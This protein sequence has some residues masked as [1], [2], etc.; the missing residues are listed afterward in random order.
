MND[1]PASLTPRRAKRSVLLCGLLLLLGI[2]VYGVIAYFIE[3]DIGKPIQTSFTP[4]QVHTTVLVVA[5]LALCF[6]WGVRCVM[7]WLAR[8]Y[9]TPEEYPMAIGRAV[10]LGMLIAEVPV[11]LGLVAYLITTNVKV[12]ALVCAIVT[13]GVLSHLIGL[14][15]L[16]RRNASDS[17][18]ETLRP[19]E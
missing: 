3:K 1:A 4:H 11:L 13:V 16:L 7:M 6:S 2:P 8:R 17:E 9:T 10:I 18:A 14:G 19:S 15:A 5:A 12:L